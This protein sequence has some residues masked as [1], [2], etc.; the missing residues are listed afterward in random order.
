VVSGHGDVDRR[1]PTESTDSLVEGE[2]PTGME[3][4][5]SNQASF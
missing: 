1:W 5:T 3:Q 4:Q 2:R